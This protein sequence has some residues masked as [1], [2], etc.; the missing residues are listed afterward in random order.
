MF[1]LGGY[2]IEQ[3]LNFLEKNWYFD[4]FC[5][6]K[7]QYANKTRAQTY[8]SLRPTVRGLTLTYILLK[9]EV[10]RFH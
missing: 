10:G 2:L 4:G 7:G 1:Y 9:W 3:L 8:S 6:E 5:L